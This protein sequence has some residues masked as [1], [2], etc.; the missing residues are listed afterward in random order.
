M[1]KMASPR[2]NSSSSTGSRKSEYSEQNVLSGAMRRHS[3]SVYESGHD[4]LASICIKYRS[5]M[6]C[7]GRMLS[8]HTTRHNLTKKNLLKASV[9][10]SLCAQQIK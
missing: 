1:L 4:V 2:K 9:F 5:C 6:I 8:E 3:W 7:A 10:K